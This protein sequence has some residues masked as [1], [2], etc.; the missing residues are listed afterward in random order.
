MWAVDQ[1]FFSL[2]KILEGFWSFP[3]HVIWA[4]QLGEGLQTLSREAS[5]KATL[6]PRKYIYIL[7]ICNSEIILNKCN[8]IWIRFNVL[9]EHLQN[10]K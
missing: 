4:C 3:I 2:P 5:C 7:L 6:S 8:S 9:N 10:D 1:L